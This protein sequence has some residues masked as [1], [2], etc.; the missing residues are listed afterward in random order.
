MFLLH[1]KKAKI[2]MSSALK[3]ASILSLLSLTLATETNPECT[4]GV[5]PPVDLS[6]CNCDLA[7]VSPPGGSGATNL[8]LYN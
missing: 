2:K 8:N 1:L 6:F 5:L 7:T 4:L 3:L